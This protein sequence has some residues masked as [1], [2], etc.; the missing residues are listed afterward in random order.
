MLLLVVGS[1]L[2][3]DHNTGTLSWQAIGEGRLNLSV[4]AQH[5]AAS[6]LFPAATKERCVDENSSWEKFMRASGIRA[7][8]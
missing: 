8:E 6:V 7:A 3:V 5:P 2:V 4:P 1:H